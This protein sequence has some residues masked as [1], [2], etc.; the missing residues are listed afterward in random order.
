MK[1]G[2]EALIQADLVLV[3]HGVLLGIGRADTRD[4]RISGVLAVN[5]YF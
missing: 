1:S 3:F 4:K 5:H 2:V